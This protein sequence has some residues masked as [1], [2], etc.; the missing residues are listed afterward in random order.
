MNFDEIENLSEENINK[1]YEETIN[2]SDDTIIGGYCYVLT[3]DAKSECRWTAVS[4]RTKA[5]IA[6]DNDECLNCKIVN[7]GSYATYNLSSNGVYA[8]CR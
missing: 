8:R 6:A 3:A 7:S 5:C 2:N 1:Y 4:G